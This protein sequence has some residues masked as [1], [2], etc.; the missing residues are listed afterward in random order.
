MTKKWFRAMEAFSLGSQDF[1]GLINKRID[2]LCELIN[3]DEVISSKKIKAI[4]W[5][6]LI[7]YLCR[8]CVVFSSFPRIRL[9][10]S[11]WI[12]IFKTV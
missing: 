1:L 6:I 2:K 10:L 5:S 8:P 7:R 9:S 3:A 11:F 12:L 4:A